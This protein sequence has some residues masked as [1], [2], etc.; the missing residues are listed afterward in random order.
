MTLQQIINAERWEFMMRSTDP[1]SPEGKVF[2][3]VAEE[4]TEMNK[5]SDAQITRTDME[6]TV[7]RAIFRFKRLAK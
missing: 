4:D 5:K 3:A 7:D 1:Q 2:Q 6:R